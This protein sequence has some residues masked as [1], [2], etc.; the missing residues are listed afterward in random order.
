MRFPELRG[1]IEQFSTVNEN[2]RSLCGAFED[3]SLMLEKLQRERLQDSA[4][5]AEYHELCGE[6][7]HDIRQIC[8]EMTKTQSDR[9]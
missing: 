8:F 6:L 5:A 3:A 1:R 4:V 2:L 7:E 9:G